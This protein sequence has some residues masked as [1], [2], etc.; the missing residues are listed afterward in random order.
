MKNKVNIFGTLVAMGLT[1]A[2]CVSCDNLSR[3]HVTPSPP[4][5]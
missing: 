5:R 3:D 1:L 2:V 4:V